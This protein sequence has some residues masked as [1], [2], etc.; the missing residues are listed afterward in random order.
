[1]EAVVDREPIVLNDELIESV[2]DE[3]DPQQLARLAD[4]LTA[5]GEALIG[6]GRYEDAI[7][8][9]D[10]LID[11]FENDPA[12][13]LERAVVEALANKAVALVELGREDEARRVARD[14]GTRFG[15]Q[16]AA[17]FEEPAGGSLRQPSRN[18]TNSWQSR[19]TAKPWSSV[20]SAAQ[21]RRWP[22]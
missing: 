19:S 6:L 14:M 17:V 15:D 13:G 12:P 2:S 16:A 7:A 5:N 9:L 10:V 18:R 8:I 3:T 21:V 1:M 11:R 20:S 4:A 22:R